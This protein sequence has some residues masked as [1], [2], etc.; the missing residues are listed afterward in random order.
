MSY[1]IY[2]EDCFKRMSLMASKSIDLVLCDLPFGR[3]RCQWDKVLPFD[4]LWAEYK[5]LLKSGGAVV[6]FGTEPFSSKLRLSN[7]KW[8]KYDW[9]W[10]KPKGV[11]H[12][13]AH[14]QPMRDVENISVFY[15]EQCTYNPQYTEGEPYKPHTAKSVSVNDTSVSIYGGFANGGDTRNENVGL[16]Y[17]TQVLEFGIVERNREHQSQKPVDLLEYLIKTYTNEGAVVLDNTMGS[18]STGVACLNLNRDFVGIE[19]DSKFFEVAKRRLFEVNGEKP[20]ELVGDDSTLF[21][22]LLL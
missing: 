10:K 15:N 12:L 17:P 16:R 22:G 20:V 19:I 3:T 18:G 6:L 7:E 1:R 11:G 5:R 9:V 2:N 21:G 8:Y 4:K 14:R 13:N